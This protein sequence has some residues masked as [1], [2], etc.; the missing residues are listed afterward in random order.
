M[1]R[2]VA[3]LAG[4]ALAMP[5]SACGD[6]GGAG[7]LSAGEFRDQAQ[8]ICKDGNAA[9]DEVAKD[10]GADG[11]TRDQLEEAAPKVPR[12]IDDELD[13]LDAL[14]PPEDLAEDVEAMLASFRAVVRSM[15]EQGPAFFERDDDPFGEAYAKAEALGLEECAH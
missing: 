10:F 4:I 12:L 7:S 14:V 9:I 6:D 11:P 2:I 13:R 3:M 8:A 5:V 15:E 1:H